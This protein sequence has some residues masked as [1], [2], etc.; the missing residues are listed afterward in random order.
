[1]NIFLDGF[2]FAKDQDMRD[3]T[4][5]LI[6]CQQNDKKK[7]V[8]LPKS[9]ELLHK[10][11]RESILS[12][13]STWCCITRK[14]VKI[15]WTVPLK[16]TFTNYPKQSI[17]M[18]HVA[19]A[20]T[21]KARRSVSPGWLYHRKVERRRADCR[22]PCAC[23]RHHLDRCLRHGRHPDHYHPPPPRGRM[24][25]RPTLSDETWRCHKRKL[26]ANVTEKE[27]IRKNKCQKHHGHCFA[28]RAVL[29]IWIRMNPST[30]KHKN[31]KNF[32]FFN[33]VT[34]L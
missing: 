33:F 2:Y 15:M 34:S 31:K 17:K 24:P 20:H 11:S 22:Y 4:C 21:V 28:V 8:K 18:K 10:Y 12:T 27:K 23:G 7:C 16:R 1:M 19:V 6:Q 26:L 3:L 9:H 14:E 30:N 13:G 25:P 29:Q 5:F 32:D